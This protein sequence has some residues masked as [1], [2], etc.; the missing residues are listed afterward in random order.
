MTNKKTRDQAAVRQ[1]ALFRRRQAAGM[2]RLQVWVTAEQ[3]E[4]ILTLL[5]TMESNEKTRG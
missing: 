4:R 3:K 2:I 5:K 1:A